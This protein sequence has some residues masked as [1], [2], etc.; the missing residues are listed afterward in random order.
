MDRYVAES[1]DKISAVEYTSSVLKKSLQVVQDS[2]K[3]K[4]ARDIL[5]TIGTNF[6]LNGNDIVG[7]TSVTSAIA[8]LE[9]YDDLSGE[10]YDYDSAHCRASPLMRDLAGGNERDIISFYHKRV[11]CSCLQILYKLYKSKPKVGECFS[12]NKSFLRASLM[13]CGG[14]RISQFCSVKCQRNAWPKHKD[15]CGK[16]SQL[17]RSLSNQR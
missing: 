12:C 8:L 15:V 17:R 13:I 1:S 2:D 10:G 6:L 11:P 9:C 7:A 14:C 5:L 16:W 4:S 3:R